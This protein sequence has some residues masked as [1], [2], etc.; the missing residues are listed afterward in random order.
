MSTP[1]YS[2]THYYD[3]LYLFNHLVNDTASVT[4]ESQG[5]D[6]TATNT[7]E[8]L[9][10]CSEGKLFFIYSVYTQSFEHLATLNLFY[11]ASWNVTE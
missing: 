7:S 8:N 3:T 2:H 6:S 4:A 10:A 9:V 1:I 5:I 11:L